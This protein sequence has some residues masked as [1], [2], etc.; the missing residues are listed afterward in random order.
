MQAAYTQKSWR[1]LCSAF[2][3]APDVENSEKSSNSL[4]RTANDSTSGP[5]EISTEYGLSR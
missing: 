3:A 5:G 1:E 4:L 2:W